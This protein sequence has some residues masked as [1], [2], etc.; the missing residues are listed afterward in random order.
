MAEQEKKELYRLRVR[1][2]HRKMDEVVID[3]RTL[4]IIERDENLE[5]LL[6]DQLI[7]KAEMIV[8]LCEKE[9]DRMW[10][11]INKRAAKEIKHLKEKGLL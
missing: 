3:L 7:D 4:P 8:E 10:N 1:N 6:L 2:L 11:P 5:E 9:L